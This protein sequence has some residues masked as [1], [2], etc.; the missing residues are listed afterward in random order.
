MATDPAYIKFGQKEQLQQLF[1]AHLVVNYYSVVFFGSASNKCEYISVCLLFLLLSL[2]LVISPF[3]NIPTNSTWF[4]SACFP[5]HVVGIP[6]WIFVNSESCSFY[7][8][9][10]LNPELN[11]Q[12]KGRRR[13]Y[14]KRN[15]SLG[16]VSNQIPHYSWDMFPPLLRS[17]FLLLYNHLNHH[18]LAFLLFQGVNPCDSRFQRPHGPRR[19]SA[20]AHLL[21]LRFRIPAEHGMSVSCE[22]CVLSDR[23]LWVG[24]ITSPED[25]YVACLSVIRKPELW[26]EPGSPGAV[27]I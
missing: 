13:C 6:T 15:P 5:F 26:S 2:V 16:R 27:T 4:I 10:S 1:C 21:C 25:S 11:Q 7:E 18:I 20:A 17:H 3:F 8:L 22:S 19:V 23:G 14:A 9:E 12:L 24:L